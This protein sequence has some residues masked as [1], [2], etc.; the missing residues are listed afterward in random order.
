MAAAMGSHLRNQH[1]KA[2]WEKQKGICHYCGCLMRKRGGGKNTSASIDHIIPVSKGGVNA[3][4]NLVLCCRG[5]NIKKADNLP[6]E[7]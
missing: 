7:R 4:H 6:T 2:L 1:K 5:C 3:R